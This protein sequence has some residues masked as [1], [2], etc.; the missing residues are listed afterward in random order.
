MTPEPTSDDEY[1]VLLLP[2]TRRDGEVTCATLEAADMTCLVCRDSTALAAH[3]Q[4]GVGAIVL[5]DA[6]VADSSV[7]QVAGALACQ[8]P[9]S[10]V[11]TILLSRAEQSASTA[12]LLSALRNVTILDR[13]T[14]RRSLVSAIQAALRGR[15]R[16][17][18]IRDQLNTLQKVEESLRTANRRKDEFLAMLAHELRNP[19]AAIRTATELLARAKPP[20]PRAQMAADLVKRQVT[21]LTR[22]VDDLM[23][24]SRITQGRIQLQRRPFEL[25]SIVAQAIESVEPLL[26]EKRHMVSRISNFESLYV[27]GDSA[28]LLQCVT[29]LLTNA[30]KYT[31]PAGKIRVELRGDEDVAVIS[32]SDNGIG[33]SAELLPSIFDLFVQSSRSLDR[34]DGGLGIGLSVVQR[35]VRMHG[36]GVR[37]ASDGPGRGA[38]FEIRLPRV[39]A[40]QEAASERPPLR[41]N[42]KRILVVDDNADA[43]NTLAELLRLDGHEAQTVHSAKA[44]LESI[45]K[46]GPD[47]VLLDIG[48]PE[49]DGYQVAERI[50]ETSRGIR[51]IALTGY[52]QAEDVARTRAAGFDVH[53]VKPV[54]FDVLQRAMGA[55]ETGSAVNSA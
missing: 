22:L 7:A 24:V 41:I 12:R 15:E 48:L 33:I 45:G 6:M 9:W 8:P 42:P 21:H 46:Y 40:P 16:Q 18:Q 37:A 19:L 39:P 31:D 10:D 27:N 55:I 53:M 29:N 51:L 25:S 4:A 2:P 47:V 52:G 26:R 54:D 50:R 43:A 3:V 5:T 14:S 36:G 30:A 38:T 32:V 49:M 13:P 11:P 35:L 34:S 17:Y 28:R 44:A 1:R 23:D 20:E